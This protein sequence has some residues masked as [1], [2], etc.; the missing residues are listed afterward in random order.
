MRFEFE[1]LGQMS[2]AEFVE[3]VRW[4]CQYLSLGSRVYV[5]SE[6]LFESSDGSVCASFNA[7]IATGELT[8]DGQVPGKLADDMAIFFKQR[9]V[10]PVIRVHIR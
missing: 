4:V 9:S 7:G 1:Q 5:G 8:L 6:G 2:V 3:F 10:Q